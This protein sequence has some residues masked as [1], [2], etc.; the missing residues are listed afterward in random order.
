MKR[1]P[2][3]IAAVLY[4]WQA[5]EFVIEGNAPMAAAFFSYAAANV[6]FAMG[7]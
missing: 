6:A 5:M 3:V 1:A 2:L 7:T 4:V